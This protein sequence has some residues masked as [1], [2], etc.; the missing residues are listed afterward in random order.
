MQGR[1]HSSWGDL[2]DRA[3]PVRAGTSGPFVCCPV[4]TAVGA[5]NQRGEGGRA[6]IAVE[7]VQRGQRPRRRDLKDG[8]TARYPAVGP[9]SICCPV[10]IPIAG[11]N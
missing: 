10:E 8:S 9:A 5:L 6:V 3:A 11:L 4:K 2:E 7:A 1:Q